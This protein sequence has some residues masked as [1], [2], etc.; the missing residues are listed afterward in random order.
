MATV[1]LKVPMTL[2]GV[3]FE[4]GLH[5]DVEIVRDW[6][7]DEMEKTGLFIVKVGE[8]LYPSTSK[9]KVADKVAVVEDPAAEEPTA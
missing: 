9:K 7:V 4:A 1:E 6:F 5:E 8:V 2:G 3:S